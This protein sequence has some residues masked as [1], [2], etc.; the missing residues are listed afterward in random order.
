MSRRLKQCGACEGQIGGDPYH[1]GQCGV[2]GLR[3]SGRHLK[4]TGA[5]QEAPGPKEC[6]KFLNYSYSLVLRAGTNP[7]RDW[8]S[9]GRV[10]V[11]WCCQ[12]E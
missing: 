12:S 1:Q 7:P 11:A 5:N 3:H 6:Q 8:P 4:W 9:C 2:G 10:G